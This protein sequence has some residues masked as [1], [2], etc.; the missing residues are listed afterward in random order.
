MRPY[1]CRTC[2]GTE[3]YA[4]K[5]KK[6]G[7]TRRACKKCHKPGAFKPKNLEGMKPYKCAVCGGTKHY[8]HWRFYKERQ[9]WYRHRRCVACV[10]KWNSR[11]GRKPGVY[12]RDYWRKY[13]YGITP[14]EYKILWG[15]Q[16]GA[17]AICRRS[18]GE[19]AISKMCIDH[20]HD[21][22]KI[23]GLL[24]GSCNMGIGGLQ[25]NPE[26]LKRGVKYLLKSD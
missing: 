14:E 17:C 6:T 10:K 13:K 11:P 3:H 19:G 21:T 25:H 1:K 26:L 16:N 7:R 22:G 15:K 23:R 4:Y 18:E 24:C 2:G 5:R 8:A 9:K 12:D 20:C